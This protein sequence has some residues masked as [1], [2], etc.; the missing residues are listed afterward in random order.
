MQRQSEGRREEE[1]HGN[2]MRWIVVEMQVLVANIRHPV[3]VTENAVWKPVP[4]SPEQERALQAL[5]EVESPPPERVRG[6]AHKG[7]WSRVKEAFTGG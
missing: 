3:E 6:R 2:H 4:P 1:R 7:F 5:R